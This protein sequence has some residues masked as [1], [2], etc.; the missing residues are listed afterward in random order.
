MHKEFKLTK[1]GVDE[2]ETELRELTSQRV[3]IAEKLKIAREHGDLKENAE[4]HNAR[5]EQANLETRIG[6]IEH[7]LRS[8]EVI[9]TPKNK[10]IVSLGSKVVLKGQK[11]E[12]TYMIVSSVEANPMESK[13]S[14]QSPIGQALIGRRVGE[15]V[16]IELPAGTMEYKIKTI[17]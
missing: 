3:V 11:G 8:V 17:A 14:D 6:E 13:I 5:E 10:D 4:Y 2:L 9:D 15:G 16:S 7:I 12:Q 1:E